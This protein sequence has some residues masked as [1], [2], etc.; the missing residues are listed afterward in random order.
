LAKYNI[1]NKKTGKKLVLLSTKKIAYEVKLTT[2]EQYLKTLVRRA[3][4][5]GIKKHQIVSQKYFDNP[6]TIY[7]FI[8]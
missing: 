2:T 1:G 8:L 7:E 4:K 3:N 6:K 5:I